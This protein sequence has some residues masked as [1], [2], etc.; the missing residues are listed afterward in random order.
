MIPL[1]NKVLETKGMSIT[2]GSIKNSV[3]Y[4][5]TSPVVGELG[6]PNWTNNTPFLAFLLI[7][8]TK[9]GNIYSKTGAMV[10]FN[11]QHQ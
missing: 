6:V 2:R 11:G 7:L 3:R 4:F 9:L 5:F 1:T 10:D 8:N